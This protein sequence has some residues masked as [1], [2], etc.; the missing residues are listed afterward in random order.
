MSLVETLMV[1]AELTG[2]LRFIVDS[3][4][5]PYFGELTNFI[6]YLW[7][8]RAGEAYQCNRY[9]EE[10]LGWRHA[11]LRQHRVHQSRKNNFSASR[12]AQ[13][14]LRVHFGGKEGTHADRTRHALTHPDRS[15]ESDL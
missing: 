12:T 4:G 10:A 7:G 15:F 11:G 1:A 3:H 14:A 6:S 13:F 9:D 8:R 5:D 2:D